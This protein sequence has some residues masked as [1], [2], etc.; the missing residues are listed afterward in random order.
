MIIPS[1]FLGPR[2]IW[3]HCTI[4]FWTFTGSIDHGNVRLNPA[5][6]AGQS[7]TSLPL[8]PASFLHFALPRSVAELAP[9]S[10]GTTPTQMAAHL[11]RG[12][13]EYLYHRGGTGTR[14][15]NCNRRK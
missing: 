9:R 12:A 6:F 2:A 1:I 5:P 7:Q 8:H 11:Q 15:S 13:D 10:Y 14:G 4:I 3:T